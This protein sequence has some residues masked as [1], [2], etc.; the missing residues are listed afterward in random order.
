M[1]T[2]ILKFIPAAIVIG[3]FSYANFS[4][5]EK[6]RSNHKQFNLITA[7]AV[8]PLLISLFLYGLFYFFP[9]QAN[10]F[11]ILCISAPIFIYFVLILIKLRPKIKVNF[12]TPY[13]SIQSKILLAIILFIVI[14][15]G[16][17]AILWPINWDDQILY[18][19]QAY[20]MGEVKDVNFY[21][22]SKTFTSDVVSYQMNATIRPGLFILDTFFYLF[23][24]SYQ[25]L[26]YIAQTIIFYYF[27]LL[28]VT[29]YFAAQKPAKDKEKGILAVFLL[30]TCYYFINFTIYGFKEVTLCTLLILSLIQIMEINNKQKL[31]L[32]SILLGILMG[33]LSFV[34]FSG[35]VIDCILLLCL[36]F[37]S[38][39]NIASKL[40]YCF[41]AGIVTLA[42]CGNEF[43]IFYLWLLQGFTGLKSPIAFSSNI[44]GQ[45]TYAT[46]GGGWEFG[47]YKIGST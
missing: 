30:C 44:F 6:I 2:D 45:F 47:A 46:N 35:T 39:G 32:N 12:A 42:F 18:V 1:F 24:S 41:I 25:T 22:Q 5:L 40:K 16:A 14:L 10:L 21:L 3:L 15:T 19:K 36:F 20:S 26:P 29:V 11:Y 33:L 28:L 37:Y 9:H 13:L 8:S 17:R 34:N 4:V 23:N 38:P 27:L 31:I 7:L 43:Y